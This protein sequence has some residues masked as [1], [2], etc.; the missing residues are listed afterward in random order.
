[1]N[2]GLIITLSIVIA[3]LGAIVWGLRT[4]KKAN[5][6]EWDN[7]ILNYLDGFNRLI[8]VHYHRFNYQP[9]ALPNQGAAIIVANHVSGLDS[10]L[11]YAATRRP[12]RF[13]IAQEQYERFGVK[14]LFKMIN[15]IPVNYTAHPE[16]ALRLALHALEAGEVVALYPQG[17]F[18]APGESKRLKKGVFWLA[19]KTQA[20]IY[21]FYI[22]GIVAPKTIFWSLL[23]RSHAKLTAYPPVLS[24]ETDTA[25]K[26]QAIF[27][28]QNVDSQNLESRN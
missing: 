10:F 13:L 2:T 22:S 15:C 26:L 17:G 4:C 12:I 21:P 16:R 28:G 8:C 5:F 7:P 14:W 20:P 25:E 1:M 3:F 24:L 19:K 23:K 6:V 11:L 9:L 18:V 27:E